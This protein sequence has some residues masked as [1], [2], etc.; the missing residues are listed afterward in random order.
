MFVNGKTI[1]VQTIP[2]MGEGEQRKMVEELGSRMIFLIYCK[3]LCKCH[4]IPPP[5]TA[6][7]KCY[8]YL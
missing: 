2:G 3:S 1:P 7:K 5:S 6:I 4:S 8:C